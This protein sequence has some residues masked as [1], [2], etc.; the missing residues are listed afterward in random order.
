M[1]FIPNMKPRQHERVPAKVL[2]RHWNFVDWLTGLSAALPFLLALLAKARETAI[3]E[4]MKRPVA[5]RAALREAS[6]SGL[7]YGSGSVGR[8]RAWSVSLVSLQSRENHTVDFIKE[9]LHS[10]EQLLALFQARGLIQAFHDRV[11]LLCQPLEPL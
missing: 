7:G 1:R 4:C 3:S 8:G 9:K 2:T 5:L 11:E 6:F 10:P